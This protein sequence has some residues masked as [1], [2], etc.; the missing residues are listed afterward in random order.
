MTNIT[1]DYDS[2]IIHIKNTP[3][4]EIRNDIMTQ[5][6]RNMIKRTVIKIAELLII[7]MSILGV[8]PSFLG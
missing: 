3:N 6:K 5:I 7:S 1:D 8:I 2:Y 4:N